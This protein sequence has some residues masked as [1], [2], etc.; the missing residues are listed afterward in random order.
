PLL[1]ARIASEQRY[2]QPVLLR[3]H[4]PTA[5]T[6]SGHSTSLDSE[7]VNGSNGGCLS[8]ALR[9]HNLV[10]HSRLCGDARRLS[11]F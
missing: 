7:W 8:P 9:G 1:A 11:R 10:R 2:W 5:I 4:A 6:S 3:R